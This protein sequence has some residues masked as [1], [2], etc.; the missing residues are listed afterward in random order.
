[1]AKC[2]YY[3]HYHRRLRHL[4]PGKYNNITITTWTSKKPC[5]LFST[6]VLFFFIDFLNNI[7]PLETEINTLQ[8]IH[9]IFDFTLSIC[10]TL[11]DKLKNSRQLIA[12]C[13]AFCQTGRF[14]ESCS[15]FLFSYSFPVSFINFNNLAKN[16]LQSNKFLIKNL[17]SKVNLQF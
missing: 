9:E 13:S 6:I 16:Y 1:M 17:S 4:F 15:T 7:L 11:L 8:R 3:Y 14:A 2:H 5:H 10:L 12:F